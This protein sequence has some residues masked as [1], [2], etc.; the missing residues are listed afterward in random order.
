[1][2]HLSKLTLKDASPRQSLTPLARK[3]LKLLQKLDKQIEAAEAEIDGTEFVENKSQWVTDKETGERK[4]INK[5]RPFKSWWWKNEHGTL[6]LTLRDGN[7]S[8]PL[9]DKETSIEV[10]GLD[11]LI[12]TLQTV[13]LAVI[14][15]E[16]DQQLERLVAE[17]KIPQ[18]KSAKSQSA[19]A[20]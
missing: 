11:E 10:G 17:R 5:V 6:M 2:S 18:R 4:L 3:R 12:S 7:K 15:G 13:R 14:A 1:M 20:A 19:K 16:L 9:S 8:I